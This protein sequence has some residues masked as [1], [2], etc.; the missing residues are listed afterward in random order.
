MPML[1]IIPARAVMDRD[2]SE[3]YLRV[4]C[5]IGMHTDRLGGNVWA[6]VS[7]L[8]SECGF[9][10]RTVQRAIAKLIEMGYVRRHER[11]GQTNLYQVVLDDPLVGIPDKAVSPYPRQSSVTPPPTSRCH[12]N[13]KKNVPKNDMGKLAQE[14]TKH[15][16]AAFPQ[17]DEPHSFPA[18]LR[19]LHDMLKNGADPDRLY[20]AA[21]VYAEE[22]ERKK[23]EP[24]YVRSVVRFYNDGIWEHYRPAVKVYGRTR[25]QWR[26]SGQDLAEFDR[27]A[28]QHST[29]GAA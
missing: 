25:E 22:V 11:T 3:S 7:T 18:A 12:P 17:R 13:D 10:E 4:L 20:A 2:L 6:S 1:S 26:M 14:V 15:V 24:R 29:E 28:E 5:A 16:L 23:T 19:A 27:L 21:V 8:A 9:S